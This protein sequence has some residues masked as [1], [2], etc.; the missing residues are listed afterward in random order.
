MKLRQRML[1]VL[2]CTMAIGMAI[3]YFVSRGVLSS[4]FQQLENDQ[5][6]QDVGNAVSA[7]DTEHLDLGKTTNDYAYWDRTYNFMG[8]PQNDDISKEFQ[9]AEMEGLAL[10]L[11]LLMDTRGKIIFA[12]G[13]D[14]HE[15]TA[16]EVPRDFLEKLLSNPRM[17]PE[18]AA[19]APQD[20]LLGF[21]D[22]VYLLSTWPILTSQR[23]GIPRGLLMAARKFDDNGISKV[24]DLTR[25]SISFQRSSPPK[26][27]ASVGKGTG[28][29]LALARAVVVDKHGG[30]IHFVTE[31]G[32]GTTF[33]I[34]LPLSA[35][36]TRE[37]A[38]VR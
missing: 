29:G 10:N 25:T 37:E 19:R 2:A 15:H 7:V 31:M 35:A 28:Q 21:L 1:A 14:Q 20:G 5:M 16:V 6:R 32:Q 3:L 38:L 13:Y 24:T 26:G 30:T 17:S 18:A 8:N 36:A 27:W 12:K 33:F 34:R 4:S 22:A 23:S 9:D 11:I